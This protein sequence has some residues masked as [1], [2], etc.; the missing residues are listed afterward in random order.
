MT[1][2]KDDRLYARFDI[3]MDEH[4]KVMLLSDLAFRVLVEATLYSRRQ[5]TDGFLAEGVVLRKWGGD[6]ADEL[7]SNHP[8]RP[9]WIRVEGGWQIRDYAEHQTTRADI[10]VKRDAGRKGGLAKAKHAASK[11]VA[12][13]SD[14]LEQNASTWGSTCLAKTETETKTTTTD[15][16]VKNTP[17]KAGRGSRLPEPFIVTR[18][19]RAWASGEVATIDVDEA[20]RSFVDYWRGR[21]GAG[22]TKLDWTATWRNSLRAAAKRDKGGRLTPEDNTRRILSLVG[23]GKELER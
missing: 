14:L 3:G 8:E 7:S 2:K 9:S 10:E 11:P 16:V 23:G 21:A 4:P 22:G 19:M 20:T 18:E 13:A 6:V 15:V 17:A 5:L 1:A 12:P